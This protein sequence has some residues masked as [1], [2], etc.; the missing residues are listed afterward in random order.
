MHGFARQRL[1]Q[2]TCT[3]LFKTSPGGWG[4]FL[5]QLL[6]YLVAQQLNSG[7]Y[8]LSQD[9]VQASAQCSSSLHWAKKW[10]LWYS[11]SPNFHRCLLKVQ[12]IMQRSRTWNSRAGNLWYLST[13]TSKMQISS[14]SASSLPPPKDTIYFENTGLHLKITFIEI[15]FYIKNAVLGRLKNFHL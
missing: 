6:T 5:L 1:P 11:Y 14:Y 13:I 12:G 9:S 7:P 3:V 4:V 8:L 2:R 10:N 15:T